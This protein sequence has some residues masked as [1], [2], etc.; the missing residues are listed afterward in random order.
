MSTHRT[1]TAVAHANIA[2]AKY[3]G[4]ADDREN[5][6]AVPSLSLTLEALRSR[7]RVEVAPGLS[8]D[9]I[10]LDGAPATG[11]A[12]D[13]VVRLLEELRALTGEAAYLRVASHNDF[14]TAAGLASSASGFAALA[15]GASQA[16]GHELS[17]EALS[18]LARRASASAARSLFGGFV[19][20]RLGAKSAEMVLDGAA[21]PLAMVIA[22]TATGPKSVSS[23]DGM[24]HT[25]ATSPYYP[26]WVEAAPKLFAEVEGAVRA[27]DLP[28]LGAAMEQSALLMHASMLGARPALVYFSPV[29]LRVMER[30]RTLRSD[31]VAAF[32]TMDAGPH[33]KVLCEPAES[34]G[35]VRALLGVAG[36]ERVIVSGPGPAAHLEGSG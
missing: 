15:L 28:T 31:G 33:V 10:S 11:R 16:L 25:L 24:R 18:S 4:K 32:Y 27:R 6:P 8:A 3:W 14:P 21:W 20:L 17:R 35:V 23:T 30:V 19:A 29:T 7:T 12:R 26:A 13:R 34:E 5:L 2:L 22:V 36:V 1:V 9:E